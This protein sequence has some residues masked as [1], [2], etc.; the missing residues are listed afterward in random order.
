MKTSW[1]DL[2]VADAHVHFFSH[3]FFA[4]LAAQRSGNSE[5][6][7]AAVAEITRILDWTTPP[8]DVVPT[9]GF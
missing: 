4:A 8:P 2:Q 5:H 3:A 1:G 7:D 6:P 9:L